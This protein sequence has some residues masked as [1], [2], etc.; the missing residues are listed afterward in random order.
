[1]G[2]VELSHRAKGITTPAIR[3]T[4]HH[5]NDNE[6]HS[7]LIR[8]SS[9]EWSLELDRRTTE[10]GKERDLDVQQLLE[11]TDLIFVGGVPDVIPT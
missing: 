1:N 7:I 5:V 10:Y 4:D 8:G 3:A 11:S 9:V 2:Y 6:P